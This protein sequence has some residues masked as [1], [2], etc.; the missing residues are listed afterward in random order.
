MDNGTAVLF[1]SYVGYLEKLKAEFGTDER[2]FLLKMKSVPL[3]I[4]D[5]IGKENQTEWS[6]ATMFDVINYRYEHLL[7]IVLTSNL[8]KEELQVYLGRAS[9]S[10]LCEIC[11]GIKTNCA[12]KRKE[13]RA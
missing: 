8:T 4:I 3:L 13:K 9:Y 7:P 2:T 11:T 6:V 1:D 10:R 12:D 5:D